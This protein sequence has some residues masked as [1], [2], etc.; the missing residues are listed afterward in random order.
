MATI[1]YDAL[2]NLQLLTVPDAQGQ[3]KTE[4]SWHVTLA[5]AVRMFMAMSTEQQRRAIIFLANQIGL[6]GSAAVLQFK[7][8]EELSQRED[9]PATYD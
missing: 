3:A 4:G 5:N 9:F 8:I 7:D 2:V 6:G 1:N